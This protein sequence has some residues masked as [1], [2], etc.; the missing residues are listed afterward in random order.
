MH[1]IHAMHAINPNLLFIARKPILISNGGRVERVESKKQV[2]DYRVHR[3][4]AVYDRQSLV[5]QGGLED[6]ATRTPSPVADPATVVT[7]TTLPCGREHPAATVPGSVQADRLTVYH[8]DGVCNV[9]LHN[10]LRCAGADGA[11]P[12]QRSILAGW[13]RRSGSHPPDRRFPPVSGEKR[14]RR[15]CGQSDGSRRPGE[16]DERVW[17]AFPR[18]ESR[19][20]YPRFHSFC[21]LPRLPKQG[22]EL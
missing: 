11:A 8:R 7:L 6:T 21:N 12:V 5:G 13:F 2:G 18:G 3:V 20:R 17:G 10:S 14:T 1:P 19:T 9:L 15:N 16:V 22:N 4:Y